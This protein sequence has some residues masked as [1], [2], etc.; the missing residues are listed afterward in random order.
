MYQNSY[1]KQDVL[2]NH[3]RIG[4]HLLQRKIITISQ[5]VDVLNEQQKTGRLLGEIFVKKG[6]ITNIQLL[7]TLKWQH[8]ADSFTLEHIIYSDKDIK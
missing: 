2:Y 3:F 6:Y 8:K 4:E 7:E 5:L 1:Y